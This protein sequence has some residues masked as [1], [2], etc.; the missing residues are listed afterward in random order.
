MKRNFFLLSALVLL[1]AAN[2][3]GQQLGRTTQFALN[4]YLVNPA[5][6]G[7][8]NAIPIFITYRNQWTGFKGAPVTMT[9]SGHMQG[10]Q[11]FGFGGILQRDDTG[12]AI[13]RT[14]I[15]ASGAYRIDLNN[16]DGISFGLGLSANQFKVD[17][18]KLVVLDESDQALNA[19]QVESTMNIDANFG[20][21]V[22]GEGYYFG[23]SSPNLIQSKLKV[24]GV[25]PEENRN[26]RQYH[27]V[28]SY[29]YDITE[30]FDIQSSGL[31]RFTNTTPI[32]LDMN[33][34]VGYK[35]VQ[36]GRDTQNPKVWSGINVR[37]NDA[38]SLS[39]GGT[40]DNFV[41]GYAMDITTSSA[42][43]MSPFTHELLVGYVIPGQRG[44]F[45]SGGGSRKKTLNKKRIIKIK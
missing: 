5:I 42:R 43:M 36:S 2:A 13:S 20:M 7:T 21:L 17:N 18:S 9:A 34:R 29:T 37:L 45:S 10:P 44:K 27:V 26:A 41:L 25:K 14:G 1:F 28:G 6:A 24:S 3:I 12:G 4:P 16:Y 19:M 35:P 23:F 39:V 38:V 32:Q 11:N 33:V 8:Q 15:E 22:F 40:Y 31:I 30:Q